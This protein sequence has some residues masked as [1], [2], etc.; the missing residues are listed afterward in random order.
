MYTR[1]HNCKITVPIGSCRFMNNF[2]NIVVNIWNL[3]PYRN[4]FSSRLNNFNLSGH[5]VVVRSFGR[6]GIRVIYFY[7]PLLICI[8]MFSLFD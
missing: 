5:L 7:L 3:L 1:G 4:S 8:F 2:K 6:S